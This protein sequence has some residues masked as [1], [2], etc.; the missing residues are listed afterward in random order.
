MVFL[1]LV[2]GLGL[3][4]GLTGWRCSLVGLIVVLFVLVVLDG[5]VVA[6][7]CIEGDFLA[8]AAAIGAASSSLVGVLGVI[9]VVAVVKIAWN[10]ANAC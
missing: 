1:F 7:A 10:T 2:L 8:A 6:V 9:F 3:I 4:L 5:A